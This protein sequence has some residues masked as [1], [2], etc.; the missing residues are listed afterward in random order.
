MAVTE[1]QPNLQSP[2]QA[3]EKIPVETIASCPDDLSL[4]QDS[5]FDL[6]FNFDAEPIPKKP[7]VFQ[8]KKGQIMS[9]RR[10]QK[11]RKGQTFII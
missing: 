8:P 6:S 5:S 10:L 4:D 3:S 9:Y 7:E 11:I 2:I 1:K